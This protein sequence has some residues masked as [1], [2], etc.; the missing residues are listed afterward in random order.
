M[1]KNDQFS[2]GNG[3]LKQLLIIKLKHEKMHIKHGDDDFIVQQ[4]YKIRILTTFFS[5]STQL[6][7]DCLTS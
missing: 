5:P 2:G 7:S 6:M 1:Y 4:S 3:I